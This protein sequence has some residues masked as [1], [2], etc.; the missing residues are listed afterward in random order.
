MKFS[1][2]I[3]YSGHGTKALGTFP[4]AFEECISRFMGTGIEVACRLLV[5]DCAVA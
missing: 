5:C 4:I 3:K 1:V 2:G